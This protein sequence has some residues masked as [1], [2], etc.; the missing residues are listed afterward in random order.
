MVDVADLADGG[1]ALNGDHAHLARGHAKRGVLSFTGYELCAGAC[2]TGQLAALARTHLYIVDDGAKR[3]VRK[4]KAISGFDIGF[5]TG[6]DLIADLE[7][8]WGKNVAL[9]AIAEVE[10]GNVGRAVGVVFDSCHLG[11]YIFLIALEVD[12]AIAPLVAASALP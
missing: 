6:H 2:G 8:D 9:L 4:L 12:Y 11:R 10:Q 3:Q 5:R 7:P 1:L